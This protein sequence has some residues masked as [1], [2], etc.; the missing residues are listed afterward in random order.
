MSLYNSY[1]KLHIYNYKSE[2]RYD[3]KSLGVL[4]YLKKIS[5]RLLIAMTVLAISV[6]IAAYD[7]F[8]FQWKKEN[9][10]I[11][12]G[13]LTGMGLCVILEYLD[14]TLRTEDGVKFYARLPYM[15]EVPP[16][17]K[18]DGDAKV[19]NMIAHLKPR[20]MMAETF[21]NIRV[22]LLFA[23]PETETVQVLLVGSSVLH[24]GKTFVASNM[25]IAFTQAHKGEPTLLIDADLRR[26]NLAEFFGID[27]G[28]GVSTF[29][30]GETGLDEIISE[31]PVPH[32]SLMPSGPHVEDPKGLLESAKLGELIQG[33][34]G[35]FKRIVVDVPA[36]MTCDDI[37]AW[38]DK[39]DDLLYVI[40][41]GFTTIED[42]AE[43]KKKM[44]GKIDISG[45]ILNNVA[46][47]NDL[48][49]YWSYFK[50][51]MENK[52]FQSRQKKL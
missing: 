18:A 20:S 23:K 33:A 4:D 45:A 35:K 31:T 36:V 13:L 48:F 7:R 40:G 11:L 50:Y 21:R 27:P 49:Y 30:K 12:L 3:V 1:G 5:S 52:L 22:N 19:A 38:A 39:C 9:Y 26:G 46:L 41:S 15:G 16:A 47:Q 28:K 29:L 10:I 17:L 8:Y 32:L 43:A 6:I 44:E 42:I 37:L 51:S 2:S 34:R 14:H 25:A 24:E